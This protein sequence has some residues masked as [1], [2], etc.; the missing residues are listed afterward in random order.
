MVQALPLRPST[1]QMITMRPLS[2][3][4]V[5]PICV[6]SRT[7]PKGV[8][9][10]VPYEQKDDKQST[11]NQEWRYQRYQRLCFDRSSCDALIIQL[12]DLFCQT[13]VIH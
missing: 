2:H 4:G 8:L 3:N 11:E 1:N 5:D 12:F 7:A 10:S 9:S 13:S 6:G